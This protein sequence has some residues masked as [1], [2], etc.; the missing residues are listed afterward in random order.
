MKPFPAVFLEWPTR[1]NNP[2]GAAM[3]NA[4]MEN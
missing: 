2:F 3:G 4:G 1:Y